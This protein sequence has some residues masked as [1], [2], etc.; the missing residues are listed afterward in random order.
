MGISH[1]R[2]TKNAL[3]WQVKDPYRMIDAVPDQRLS[4]DPE[5]F[6]KMISQQGCRVRVYRT[7]FCP[8]TKTVD[9][10][11]HDIDCQVK[12]CNGSGFLDL[13]PIETMASLYSQTMDKNG[14]PEG[15]IEG[16]QAYA[17]FLQGIELQ[18]FTLV[19][20]MD[21]T[22]IYFERVLRSN[23]NKDVLKYSAKRVNVLVDQHGTEYYQAI[24]FILDM[25]GD[26][27]WLNQRTPATNTIYSIHYE[28]AVQFRATKAVKVN[29]FLQVKD[30]ENPGNV[31]FVKMPE[32]WVLTK[33]YLVKRS[34]VNGNEIFPNRLYGTEPDAT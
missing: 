17:T 13:Y 3:A 8:N 30:A 31:A 20:L 29:R 27:E 1:N 18:Y 19:E 32:N 22:E 23:G 6:D 10:A 16:N 5:R 28:A 24:D 4:M 11:E 2:N 33:E 7:L 15:Y 25:N 9:S 26:V 21:F 14:A 12:G 34:D